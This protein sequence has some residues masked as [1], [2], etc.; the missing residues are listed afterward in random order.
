MSE[1][2]N[3]TSAERETLAALMAAAA[4]EASRPTGSTRPPWSGTLP[5]WRAGAVREMGAALMAADRA[6]YRISKP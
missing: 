5:E 2:P 1:A 6:G 4:Y 3:L